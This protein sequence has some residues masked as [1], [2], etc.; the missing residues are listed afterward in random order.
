[1]K[2]IKPFP[3]STV[4]V[5]VRDDIIEL[6]EED[7]PHTTFR[8]RSGWVQDAIQARLIQKG[9]LDEN[10]GIIPRGGGGKGF[11]GVIFR[12]HFAPFF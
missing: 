4:G 11:Q 6:I 10:G 3:T 2:S 12:G 1:M 9:Y 7:L 8:S 5:R